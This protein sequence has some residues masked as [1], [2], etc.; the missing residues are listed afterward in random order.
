MVAVQDDRDRPRTKI[1]SGLSDVLDQQCTGSQLHAFLKPFWELSKRHKELIQLSGKKS[2]L[3]TSITRCISGGLIPSEKVHDLIRRSEENG[4]QHV[5]YFKPKAA[6]RQLCRDGSEVAEALFG[7]QWGPDVF[8]SYDREPGTEKWVDFRVGVNGRPNDWL[9]KIYGHERLNRHRNQTR[10]D[11]DES[12]FRVIHEFDIEHYSTVFIVRWH[13]AGLL[14]IR[15][16]QSG[17]TA[18]KVLDER[19]AKIWN[20][21]PDPLIRENFED[22]DL[23]KA[24]T[25][26]TT[27]YKKLSARL[28][29]GAVSLSDGSQGVVSFDPKHDNED[30]SSDRGREVAVHGLLKNGAETRGLVLYWQPHGEDNE[31]APKELTE[32]LRV[33][34]ATDCSN[35][36]FITSKTT[37]SAVDYVTNQLRSFAAG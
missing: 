13:T 32:P 33:V 31:D 2:E 27:D 22:W 37:P 17:I 8:P 26:I 5:Y 24:N 20:M 1:V 7:D 30:I 14:E 6:V 34:I 10:E 36:I 23:S 4:H 12:S 16:D 15:V 29:V 18:K 3:V 19:I 35:H 21:L 11:V 25:T 9:A 28:R